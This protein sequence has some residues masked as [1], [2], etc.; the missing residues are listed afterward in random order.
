MTLHRYHSAGTVEAARIYAIR[1]E[2]NGGA[3]FVLE[4]ADGPE[5]TVDRDFLLKQQPRVGGY[6]VLHPDGQESWL[7]QDAF[8]AI[9][10]HFRP[11]SVRIR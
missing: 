6:Y 5:I 10:T 2:I 7:Q 1:H 11:S 8:P 3:T 4:R 9:S